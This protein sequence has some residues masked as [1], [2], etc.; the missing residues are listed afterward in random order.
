[1]STHCL[2][3]RCHRP[4]EAATNDGLHHIIGWH[5]QRVLYYT[6]SCWINNFKICKIQ[7][8]DQQWTLCIYTIMHIHQHA[9]TSYVNKCPFHWTAFPVLWYFLSL[10]T[11]TEN[12]NTVGISSNALFGNSANNF[13]PLNSLDAKLLSTFDLL[14]WLCYHFVFVYAKIT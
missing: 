9:Y 4:L 13:E 3:C 11:N 6:C 7:L 5:R 12:T 1:M 2:D 8:H 14:C 10:R